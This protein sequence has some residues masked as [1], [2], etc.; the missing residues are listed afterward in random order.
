MG[1]FPEENTGNHRR[2]SE[3]GGNGNQKDEGTAVGRPGKRQVTHKVR[4]EGELN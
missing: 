1:G 2:V 4:G 3:T